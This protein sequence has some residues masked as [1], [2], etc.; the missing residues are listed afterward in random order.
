MPYRVAIAISGAVSLG[1]YEAGTLYE[2]INAIKTHNNATDTEQHIHIDVLTG[3]SAGGMT[4][5]LAAQKLLY[6]APSLSDAYTN[7]GY[8]AWVKKVDIEGLL[9]PSDGDNPNTS[10][11]SSGFVD[12]I[13]NTLMLGRYQTATPPSPLRHDASAQQIKLGLALSNLNGVDYARPI[14]A[15]TH[16]G[17]VEDNF[18]ETRYQDRLTVTLGEQDDAPE[19]WQRI[20]D[21]SRACGAFPF[22]FS[23]V[24][25]QR[26]WQEP[27]YRGRGAEDFSDKVNAGKFTYIDGGAF[28]NYPLGMA[29]ELVKQIDNDPLDY[30]KRYYFYIS[31]HSKSSTM[32]AHLDG[33]SANFLMTDVALAGASAIFGQSRFQDWLMTDKIN[34]QIQLLDERAQQLA[35]YVST[36]GDEEAQQLATVTEALLHTLYAPSTDDDIDESLEHALARLYKQYHED[37]PQFS[38]APIYRQ[39]AF[40]YSVAAFEK[41]AGLNNKDKMAVYTITASAEQLASEKLGAFMGFFDERLRHYD[42]ERGRAN[43]IRVICHILR[44]QALGTKDF[45]HLPLQ[46]DLTALEAKGKAI[47]DYLASANINGKP[48]ADVDVFDLP[49]DLRQRLYERVKARFYL[50]SQQAGMNWLTRTALYHVIVKRRVKQSLHL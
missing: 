40:I 7:A 2:I 15:D 16:H 25:I 5:A 38:N 8:L 17:L 35:H 36:L 13:A 24:T 42:Y 29:R 18:I 45:A 6:E 1:S 4:A 34:K 12:S 28:N 39:N 14:F 48:M 43:A 11:V 10:I 32:N 27:D 3:A 31:P 47:E 20:I 21:A 46:L 19:V 33:D 44:Q 37:Y 23:P 9:T 22:A 49:R 41:S 30:A 26:H 50:V